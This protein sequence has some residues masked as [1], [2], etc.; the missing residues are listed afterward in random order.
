MEN[1][2]RIEG[3]VRNILEKLIKD[4][5]LSTD[6][7][8][9]RESSTLVLSRDNGVTKTVTVKV[10][11]VFTIFED[12]EILYV[13]LNATTGSMFVGCK[14][15]NERRVTEYETLE[16]VIETILRDKNLINIINNLSLV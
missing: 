2:K 15:I 10:N 7:K 11:Q 3:I 16:T 6:L 5:D 8:C 13:E 1:K 4:F 12:I 14:L 9:T